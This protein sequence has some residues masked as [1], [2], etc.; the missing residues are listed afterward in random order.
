MQLQTALCCAYGTTLKYNVLNQTQIICSLRVSHPPS[1]PRKKSGCA[2]GVRNES[3][4]TSQGGEEYP[5]YS[6]MKKG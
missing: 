3:I 6:K 1:P 5:T 2:S 4:T